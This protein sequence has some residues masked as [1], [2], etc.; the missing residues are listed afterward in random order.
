MKE[1]QLKRLGDVVS[2]KEEERSTDLGVNAV[3]EDDL[4]SRRLK[5]YLG[6]TVY[7]TVNTDISVSCSDGLSPSG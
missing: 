3:E 1:D 5:S 6:K 2:S 7:S 4:M